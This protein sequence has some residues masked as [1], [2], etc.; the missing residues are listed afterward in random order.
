MPSLQVLE[1]VIDMGQECGRYLYQNKLLGVTINSNVKAS[2]VQRLES[3]GFPMFNIES[4][5]NAFVV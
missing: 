2:H 4:I 1:T 5:S 3:M